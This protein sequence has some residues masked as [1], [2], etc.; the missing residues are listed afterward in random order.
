M[1]LIR[2]NHTGALGVGSVIIP[3][4]SEA[5]VPNW[6]GVHDQS[7]VVRAWTKRGILTVVDA[8]IVPPAPAPVAVAAPEPEPEDTERAELFAALA[9]LGIRPGGRTGN[10]KLR[11]MLAEARAETAPEPTEPDPAGDF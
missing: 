11:A 9:E 8:E 3:A 2:N 7:A 6:R 4:K 5:E 1:A 10:D